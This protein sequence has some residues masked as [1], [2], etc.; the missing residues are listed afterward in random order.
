[1]IGRKF[2]KRKREKR[3][4]KGAHTK[5]GSTIRNN[6]VCR[7]GERIGGE[8]TCVDSK[9]SPDTALEKRWKRKYGDSEDNSRY[10]NR[11]AWKA[12]R[13]ERTETK[14]GI[15]RLIFEQERALKDD[16]RVACA[17]NVIERK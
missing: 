17:Q 5:A 7:H 2:C 9:Q 14:L 3:M 6:A 16:E 8:Q 4:K 13:F 1:M 10:N 15:E 11:V 12:K